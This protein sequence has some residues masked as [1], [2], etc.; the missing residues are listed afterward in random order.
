MWLAPLGPHR[1]HLVSSPSL[2]QGLTSTLSS[3]LVTGLICAVRPTVFYFSI[4]FLLN[5]RICGWKGSVL[6]QGGKAEHGYV[7]LLP[8]T[9]PS[10]VCSHSNNLP[11][12]VRD[13]CNCSHG[14]QLLQEEGAALPQILSETLGFFHRA[15][16]TNPT[17]LL[18]Q[19]FLKI[20]L[21]NYTESLWKQISGIHQ[22]TQ[23]NMCAQSCNA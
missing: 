13:I 10:E 7:G 22:R 11:G 23:M 3:Q 14:C 12:G 15:P 18:L 4:K 21:E 5:A 20:S 8:P 9:S 2:R 6:Q 17:Q 1:N 19:F 16:P